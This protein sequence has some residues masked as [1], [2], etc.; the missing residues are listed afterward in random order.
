[1]KFSK[2][3]T[4]N[5]KN[6]YRKTTPKF[7]NYIIIIIKIPYCVINKA[8]TSLYNSTEFKINY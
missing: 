4:I 8:V 6:P 5:S 3:T 7:K 1:M 2:K